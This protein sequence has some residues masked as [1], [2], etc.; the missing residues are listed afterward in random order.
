M[1][2]TAIAATSSALSSAGTMISSTLSS[3][4]F[5]ENV[6][7][8]FA[9]FFGDIPPSEFYKDYLPLLYVAVMPLLCALPVAI[10]LCRNAKASRM[11]TRV[12]KR[13]NVAVRADLRMVEAIS[14]ASRGKKYKGVT[15]LADVESGRK[16]NKAA[17]IAEENA[18]KG[19]ATRGGDRR[20]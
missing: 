9:T 8:I 13:I 3:L 12:M 7:A 4:P 15:S 19:K 18:I 14:P 10:G 1:A 2:D 16:K 20:Y 6:L 11:G 17:G 5:A